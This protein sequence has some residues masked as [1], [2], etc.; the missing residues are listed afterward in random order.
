MADRDR[1]KEVS[2]FDGTSWGTA[3]P[4]GADDSN[5]DITYKTTQPNGDPVS[6][7]T[8]DTA[9]ALDNAAVTVSEGDTGA[10]AWTKFNRFRKRV[11]NN[12]GNYMQGSIALSY[13]STGSDNA[14]YSTNVLNNYMANV[15]GYSGT[16]TPT[17]GTVAAQLSS[18]NDNKMPYFNII[19]SSDGPVNFNNMTTPGFYIFGADDFTATCT[20][21]PPGNKAGLLIVAPYNATSPS[22]S[23]MYIDQGQSF[24]WKR[25][26]RYWTSPPAWTNWSTGANLFVTTHA[27]ALTNVDPS[28]SESFTFSIANNTAGIYPMGIVG[29]QTAGSGVSWFHLVSYYL[30]SRSQ[31]AGTIYFA[32][33]NTHSSK[34][35]GS[36]ITYTFS[37]LWSRSVLL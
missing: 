22:G 36:G 35:Y 24:I 5:I 14:V 23:Q 13:N 26:Y 27:K 28:S 31:N 25:Y 15:I 34:A 32:V 3:V 16:T 17:E 11:I 2:A 18:L 33:R 1:I 9:L 37:V 4:L 21:T 12:F 20:N 19:K 7:V 6:E 29:V 30:S 8:G 10:S